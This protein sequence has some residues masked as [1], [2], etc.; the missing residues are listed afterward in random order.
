MENSSDPMPVLRAVKGGDE[1]RSLLLAGLIE[2]A[3]LWTQTASLPAYLAIF[4]ALDS[5]DEEV[6]RL[7]EQF[8]RRSSPRSC[9]Q[10]REAHHA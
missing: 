4:S 3:Q 2:A 9:D 5:N 8:L 7:A 6:R 10:R 1:R